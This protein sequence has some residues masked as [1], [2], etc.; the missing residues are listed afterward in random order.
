MIINHCY[1]ENHTIAERMKRLLGYFTEED[2][3]L[4]ALHDRESGNISIEAT[5]DIDD[6]L[7]ETTRNY[8]QQQYSNFEGIEIDCIDLYREK[9]NKM[10]DELE[11]ELESV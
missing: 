3:C 6:I 10:F 11:K 2:N 7:I 5:Y 4:L 8:I 1:L 9:F